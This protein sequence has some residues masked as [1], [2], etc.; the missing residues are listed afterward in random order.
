MTP[1]NARALETRERG[2]QPT[3]GQGC[4]S[5]EQ[6]AEYSCEDGIEAFGRLLH[7]LCDAKGFRP[8]GIA[9]RV[10][11]MSYAINHEMMGSEKIREIEKR[12]NNAISRQTVYKLAQQFSA[13]FGVRI[14]INRTMAKPCVEAEAIEA[15]GDHG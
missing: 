12:T 3:E 4:F 11:A 9:T 15:K 1:I 10:I 13:E 5:D 6:L 14:P 7:W 2:T 8:A